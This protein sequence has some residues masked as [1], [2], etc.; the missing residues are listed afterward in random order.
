MKYFRIKFRAPHVSGQVT[1]EVVADGGTQ[2]KQILQA[3]YAGAQIVEIQ[4]PFYRKKI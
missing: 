4:G 3:R 1:D 2:A